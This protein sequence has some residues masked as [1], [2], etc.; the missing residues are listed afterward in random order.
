[1]RNGVRPQLFIHS[2]HGPLTKTP[3]RFCVS[4]RWCVALIQKPDTRASRP[5]FPRWSAGT[6]KN[7]TL[8]RHNEDIRRNTRF[9][10]GSRG[11]KVPLFF[12]KTVIVAAVSRNFLYR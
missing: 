3:D 9:L 10:V 8:G 7:S 1:M 12:V 4:R 11:D 6:I 2:G 5:A